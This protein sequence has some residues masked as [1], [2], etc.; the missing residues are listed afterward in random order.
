MK[1]YFLKFFGLFVGLDFF[2]RV[3]KRDTFAGMVN[4]LGEEIIKKKLYNSK[5]KIF[6]KN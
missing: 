4:V 1:G 6:F 5:K 3:N 2:R